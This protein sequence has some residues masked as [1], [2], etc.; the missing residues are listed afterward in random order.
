M[1][2]MLVNLYQLPSNQENKDRLKQKGIRIERA[3]APDRHKVMQFARENFGEGWASEV[4]AA[5][6]NQPVSCYIAI[7]E[8]KVVGFAC[9]EATAKDYFGP[10]GVLEAE[11]GQGIG[12][13][14][15]LQSMEGLREAGYGYAIIGSAGPVHFYEKC[16]GAQVIQN[17]E[18]NVYSR[19]I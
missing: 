4:S 18:P 17:D 1:P 16:C 11:R 13:A 9:Y 7:K 15:L 8:K 12:L 6:S 19:M 10:T 14:L 2:D 3:L 5:F